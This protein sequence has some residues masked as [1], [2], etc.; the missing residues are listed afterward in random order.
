MTYFHRSSGR[1]AGLLFCLIALC[2]MPQLAVARQGQ[3][4]VE[5]NVVY[6]TVGDTKLLLDVYQPDGGTGK[7]PGIVLVHGGGWV[8]GDKAFY[9]PMG[10]R[11]AAKGYD[12]FSINYRLAPTFHYPAQID[13]TQ[14]AVRWIRA[15]AGDYSLDPDRLGALGDSAG[16][17]LVEI[18]GTRDT[19][20]NS[21]RDLAGYS[22]RVQCVIDLYGPS[23]FTLPPTTAGISS[24]ALQILAMYFGKT[25]D[26]APDL[27]R[28]GSPI[29]YVD[30]QSSPFLIL[31]GTTDPLVPADQ[32]QRLNDALTK[33]GVETSLI[34][35]YKKGH[36]FLSPADPNLVGAM[37][38]EFFARHLKP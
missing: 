30:K 13:D 11:L 28:E 29:I 17:Y 2:L 7:R 4:K 5:T 8:A 26:Q 9:T 10:K 38:D 24:Q 32:S 15:H 22:S 27:Y 34:L 1:A 36:G 20:D 19:R 12:V 16:G 6:G 3:P 31:H 23:D 14:R 33:A 18:L 35:L 21:D 25:P 37:I